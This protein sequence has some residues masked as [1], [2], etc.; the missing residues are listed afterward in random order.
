MTAYLI[1][2]AKCQAAMQ[3]SLDQ[4]CLFY[5]SRD[6]RTDLARL[7]IQNGCKS[8]HID[9]YGQTPIFY[10]SREGYLEVMKILVESGADADHLDNEGQSPIFYSIKYQKRDCIDFL[11]KDCDVNIMREDAKGQNLI[12][13]AAKYKLFDIIER[14]MEAGVQCPADVKRRLARTQIKITGVNHPKAR[15]NVIEKVSE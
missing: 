14:L 13:Y 4:T 9:S 10:A 1:K 3:D 5:V 11:I 8:N 12:D 15:D 2:E 7:F 6:G